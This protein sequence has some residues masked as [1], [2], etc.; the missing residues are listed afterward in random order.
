[1]VA[2]PKDAATVMIFRRRDGMSGQEFEVL[3]VLRHPK[4][5]FVPNM[6]VFP[7]GCLDEEDYAPEMERFCSGIDRLTAQRLLRNISPP[8]KALGAWVAAI[9]ETFE[10]AGLLLAY[11]QD[12]SLL[13]LESDSQKTKFDRYRH[14][15]IE[16]RTRFV[17]IL[18]RERLTLAAD[19]LRY[20]SHW[21]TPE[22]SPYRYNVR[23]FVTEAPPRQEGSHDGVELTG[24]RWIRPEDAIAQHEKGEFGMVLPTIMNLAEVRQYRT[25]D[26]VFRSTDAKAI[27]AILTEM[28]LVGGEY[29]E[30]LP[31]D[32][33]L[34][35]LRRLY[36]G[37]VA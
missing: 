32:A 19:R 30:V 23:F 24:H 17:D 33:A 28:K 7:G 37:R 18:V 22:L 1:M 36:P 25:M 9:R 5:I 35:G 14:E 27:P 2:I 8:E 15:L 4:S 21:I 10:E 6:H 3:M 26:E 11:E 31:E 34:D 16:G 13:S 20:F 12:G 29:A